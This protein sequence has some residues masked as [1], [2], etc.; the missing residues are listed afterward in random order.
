MWYIKIGIFYEISI[1][2]LTNNNK[3]KYF[4]TLNNLLW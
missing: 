3:Y 2:I 4:K 1:E